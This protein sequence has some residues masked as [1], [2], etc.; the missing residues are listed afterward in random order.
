MNRLLVL[1][2]NFALVVWAELPAR[3]WLN[4]LLK[5]FVPSISGNYRHGGPEDSATPGTPSHA[6][7]FAHRERRRPATNP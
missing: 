6:G 1:R 5:I 3:C 7:S 2:W 4:S